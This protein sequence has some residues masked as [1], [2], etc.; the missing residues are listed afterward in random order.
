[1]SCVVEELYLAEVL[2]RFRFL[3]PPKD[4]SVLRKFVEILASVPSGRDIL[5]KIGRM[6][7]KIPVY[8]DRNL[9]NAG[10]A[11]NFVTKR[12]RILP[13][14]TSI[15]EM[16]EQQRFKALCLMTQVLAH[17]LQHV[18]NLSSVRK[19]RESARNLD[20]LTMALR[21]DEAS[22]YFSSKRVEMELGQKYPEVNEIYVYQY[23]N[24]P[25][26]HRCASPNDPNYIAN[27]G[28][29]CRVKHHV[30]TP[31]EVVRK[32]CAGEI[33]CVEHSVDLAKQQDWSGVLGKRPQVDYEAGKNEL[34]QGMSENS[35]TNLAR[36]TEKTPR[37]TVFKKIKKILSGIKGR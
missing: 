29:I 20:E 35:K 3:G 15:P 19:M 31:E 10:G 9:K 36:A 32:A 7:K 33:E 14:D 13:I 34:I 8:F 2:K 1:M 24:D 21:L 16:T 4:V 28:W 12:I 6:K 5:D 22:A 26:I 17:E 30:G 25:E 23:P 18:I 11:Y 27:K 37:V